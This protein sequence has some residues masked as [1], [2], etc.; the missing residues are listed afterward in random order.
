MRVQRAGKR[1]SASIG[2]GPSHDGQP[3]AAAR[4][5][6]EASQ[7]PASAEL[8]RDTNRLE[9]F[10]DGVF[11]VAITLLVLNLV[12]PPHPPGGLFHALV[13]LWPAYLAYLASFLYVGVVWINHHAVFKRIR[14]VDRGLFWVNLAILMTVVPT[15]FPT[16]VIADA[17][18]EGNAADSKTAAALYALTLSLNGVAWFCFFQYV[19]RRPRLLR[20]ESDAGFLR[21]DGRRAT[22]GIVSYAAAGV[23]GYLVSP[24]IALAI[25]ICLPI[26]YGVTSEGLR[27]ARAGDREQP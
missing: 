17:L 9:A 16:A 19:Q 25:F 18:R 13:E 2:A 5:A 14:A 22:V 27:S 12:V 10:S 8:R 26:F 3:D 11:A 15:A 7:P 21:I 4:E 20:R 24:V 23:L 1:V 6:H